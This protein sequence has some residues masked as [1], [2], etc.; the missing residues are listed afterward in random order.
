[1]STKASAGNTP[2]STAGARTRWVPAYAALAAI[3]GMSFLF[4]KVADRAFAP[5]QVAFGRVLLGCVVVCAVVAIRWRRLSLSPRLVLRRR[6]WGQ[7]AVAA[8]LMNTVPFT[9]LAYGEQ[10]VTSVSA[11]I[12][13]AATPLL[14]LP[15]TIWLIPSERP[16]ARRLAGL[17]AGFAG[18]LIL[19]GAGPQLSRGTLAG[20]AMCFGA[21]CSYGI[22]FPFSRR[23]LS[24]SG[25][26]PVALAAGQLMCA[27]AQL[28]VGAA[29]AAPVPAGYPPLA[30]ASVLALGAAGTGAAYI[31]NFTIV[32]DA[33]ATMA[34]TVTYVIPV[35]S[36][37][38]GVTLLG[39]HLTA[40]AVAGA[41]FIVAGAALSQQSLR[42]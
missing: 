35:C 6:L 21:A 18:V 40:G 19:L 10:R 30:T 16:G 3:W 7:L 12:W 2:E 11:G 14:A 34:S 38:A 24:S 8:L 26:P 27:V 22:G 15:A 41:L 28:A 5:A 42:R 33:G 20:D 9:L 13:N 32:R 37:A 1:M 29:L 23:F 4:I 25:L 36:T 39:E 17:A 31:L